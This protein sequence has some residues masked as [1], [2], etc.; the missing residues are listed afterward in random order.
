MEPGRDQIKP[1]ETGFFFNG[2]RVLSTTL[3]D[4]NWEDLMEDSKFKKMDDYG[5]YKKGRIALQDH[6]AD[7]WFRNI[8]IKKLQFSKEAFWL[9]GI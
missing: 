5:T 8:M 2:Q 1:R 4:D 7:V 6:G 3:W 9:D